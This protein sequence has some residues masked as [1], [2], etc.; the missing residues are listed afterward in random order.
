MMLRANSWLPSGITLCDAQE[1][2]WDVRD[3]TWVNFMQDKCFTCTI[4]LTPMVVLSGGRDRLEMY[5]MGMFEV[6]DLVMKIT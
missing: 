6:F 4:T 3:Q 1:I 5:R 2:I